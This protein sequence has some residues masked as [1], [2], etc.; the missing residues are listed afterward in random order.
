MGGLIRKLTSAAIFG[1]KFGYLP[2]EDADHTIFS[3]KSYH[4]VIRG[5]RGLDFSK[6][7][8]FRSEAEDLKALNNGYSERYRN[9]GKNLPL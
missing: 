6:T 4:A 9:P 8:H 7:T 5:P 1:H 3:S 2:V